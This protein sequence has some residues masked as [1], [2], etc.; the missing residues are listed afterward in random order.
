MNSIIQAATMLVSSVRSASDLL[1]DVSVRIQD[2][3]PLLGGAR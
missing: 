3:N 1:H 2:S